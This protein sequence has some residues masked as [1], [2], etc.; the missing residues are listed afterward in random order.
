MPVEDLKREEDVMKIFTKQAVLSGMEKK[1]I[2]EFSRALMD[3]SK[4]TQYR[5]FTDWVHC[6]GECHSPVE[7][8]EQL[9]R[10]ISLLDSVMIQSF[11]N[12]FSKNYFTP[13]EIKVLPD[14]ITAYGVSGTDKF[15]LT[16]FIGLVRFNP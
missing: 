3:I 2:Q 7:T 14:L 16:H 15:V 13:E 4:S 8:I 12:R 11:E 6:E 5:Y 9:R 10:I 1:S